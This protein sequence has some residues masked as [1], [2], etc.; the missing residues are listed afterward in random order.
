M[1]LPKPSLAATRLSRLLSAF[2]GPGGFSHGGLGLLL[3][4]A[5]YCR[6]DSARRSAY[7]L[8]DLERA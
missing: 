7:H 8:A 2:R 1:N 4:S 3:F 5:R 6:R